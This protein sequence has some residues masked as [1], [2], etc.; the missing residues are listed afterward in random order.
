MQ[1]MNPL[2]IA[3]ILWRSILTGIGYVLMVMIGDGFARLVGLPVPIMPNM[4]SHV[5]QFQSFLILFL[6][7]V[8][9]GL[10]FGPLSVKLPLSQSGRV[11]ILFFITFGINS[12][13]ILVE[14]LFFTT[15]PMPGHIYNLVS[16]AIS[17]AGMSV[18]LT[19]LFRPSEIE[20]SFSTILREALAQRSW[21]S[22]LWRFFLAGFLYLP[23]FMIFGILIQ[24]FVSIYYEDPSYGVAQL[25]S[26]PAAE[27]IFPLE[28]FRGYLFV[29]LV[30][31]LIAIL[32][33]EMS[34]WRQVVWIALVLASLSG[35]LPMLVAG[36]LPLQFRLVHGLELTFDAIVHSMVI[37][38]LLGFDIAKDKQSMDTASERKVSA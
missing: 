11:G 17:W 7:G 27:I 25:F 19:I 9:I 26:V 22:N 35:W 8:L 29:L 12:V 36:F 14:G 15:T 20:L 3:G 23:I 18:L 28:L 1:N 21:I 24:P 2:G 16:S 31:P 34:R 6:S 4:S 13:L 10:I 37:V 32:G 5:S 38:V 30:Y 33:R